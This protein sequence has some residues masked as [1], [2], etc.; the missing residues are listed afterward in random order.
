VIEIIEE[1]WKEIPGFNGRYM[2]SDI[3][4]IRSMQ[5]GV[6]AQFLGTN[7]Y[8]RVRL[9]RPSGKVSWSTVHRLMLLA[10]VGS[11][12]EGQEARHLDGIWTHNVL[13]NLCWGT[14]KENHDDRRKH[15]HGWHG[16]RNS[17][18]RLTLEQVKHIRAQPYTRGLYIRL[19]KE[20][21]VGKS[22]IRRVALNTTWVH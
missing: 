7:G 13:S 10:F 19:A 6:M 4:R 1:I 16:A 17:Q 20:F 9:T 22:T 11:C 5:R 12:P 8:L 18:A 3:G 2:V 14:P 21:G 15:G